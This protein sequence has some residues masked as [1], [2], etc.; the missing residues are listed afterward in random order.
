MQTAGYQLPGLQAINHSF[1][2]PLD[3]AT[4]E[5]GTLQLFARELIAADKREQN[6]P[7]LLYFQGGPGFGA[8]RP[9][10]KSGWLKRALQ[11][12]RVL[13]FDQRGTGAS[14]PVDV[15][16]LTHLSANEQAE[17]LTH[18][19]A[20]NIVRDA[21]H[22][23]REL[24]GDTPWSV[25]GQ[26]F[27]GFCVMRY[28]SAAPDGL[29]E[30]FIT[31]G[32]PPLSRSADDVYRA[33]YPQVTAKNQRFFTRYPHAQAL[34]QEIADYL[35]KHPT[36]LPN[37]QQL[38][39]RQFQQLGLALG[40][41]DGFEPLYYLLEHAFVTAH[42]QRTLTTQFL[43]GVFAASSFHAQPIYAIL[44]EAIYCQNSAS[45]WA[46]ER[47]RREFPAFDYAPGKPFMFTGEMVYP[48]M[49]EEFVA[50]APLKDAAELLAHKDD[51]PQLYD[52]SALANNQ[53]PVAAAVYFNDMYVDV[54][55]SLETAK[56]VPNLRTWITSEYEHNGL[57]A[58]G[59]RVLDT[60]IHLLRGPA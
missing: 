29:K 53:V 23:R 18:F 49:F 48:W 39:V 12:Y 58:D 17:Y 9:Q 56:Q 60:L 50:L 8:P 55:Y 20:D 19:R 21:E 6:L 5:K 36:Q 40:A 25:L 16:T 32:L 42:G 15:R 2:V 28:L 37:G 24:I 10:A 4:P 41:S 14:T 54:S 31:G 46:A 47:V 34:C 52:V 59:E 35:L 51:W 3:Y 43:H 11:E 7:Y 33:T 1:E 22:I 27:G 57:R 13:L 45:M 44:H 30:A 26:S 38:T